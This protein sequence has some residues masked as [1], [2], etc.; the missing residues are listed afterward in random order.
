MIPGFVGEQA[1]KVVLDLG[2][3]GSNGV[4]DHFHI[5][6]LIV[7]ENCTNIITELALPQILH[8]QLNN[9]YKQIFLY[10]YMALAC[11]AL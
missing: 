6:L 10:T 7:I 9:L 2:F 8:G 5:D 11:V 3:L 1:G 4:H